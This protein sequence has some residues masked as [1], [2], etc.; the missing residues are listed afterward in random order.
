MFDTAP[1]KRPKY[2]NLLRIRLPLP[3]IVSIMHRVSGVFL[4]LALPVAIYILDVALAGEQ[5]YEKVAA[6]FSHPILKVAAFGFLWALYHHLCAGIRFLL[7]EMH[8]GVDLAAARMSAGIALI[9]G[10]VL[11]VAHGWVLLL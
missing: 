7:I 9:A 2:L 1:A 10:I 8:I 3:G 11:A 4:I 5:G 6:A